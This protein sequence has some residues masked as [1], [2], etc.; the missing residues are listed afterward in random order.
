MPVVTEHVLLEIG[1]ERIGDQRVNFGID[2]WNHQSI[3]IGASSSISI[4]FG[5]ISSCQILYVQS[6]GS[7]IVSLP[8]GNFPL[9][10]G[11]FALIHNTNLASVNVTNGA[12]AGRLNVAILGT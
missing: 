9:I 5:N 8:S 4:A 3:R 2:E 12:T 10:S 7:C 6:P 1:A 11:G